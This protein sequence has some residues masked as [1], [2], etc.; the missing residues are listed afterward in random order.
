MMDFWLVLS[1]LI[2]A[3]IGECNGSFVSHL[4]LQGHQDLLNEKMR[5]LKDYLLV[6]RMFALYC[7]SKPSL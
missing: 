4:N 2:F 1:A 6:A 7:N 5:V 3:D